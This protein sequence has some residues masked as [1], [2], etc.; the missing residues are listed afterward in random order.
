MADL[1]PVTL[2]DP[3]SSLRASYVPGAGMICT[4]LADNSIEYVGQRRGLQ[5]Y[6][7]DGK[8]MGI[9]ILYPWANRLSANEYRVAD[10]EV[11]V[12]PGTHGVRADAHGAPI[13]GVLAASPDWQVTE[14]T[15][16]ALVAQLDWDSDQARLATFPF[17][18]RLTVTVTLEDRALTVATAV[19]P[20]RDSSVPLCYGYHPYLTIP[21]VPRQDWQLHTPTMRHLPVDDRGLPTG[22]A[23]PWP[24][25]TMRLGSTELDDGFDDVSTGAVFTLSGGPH[26]IEVAFEQGYGAAQ[27]FAPAGDSVVGIEPMTA[28]TDAL[29]HGNYKMAAPGSPETATFSISV[30]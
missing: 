25:G 29:R 15:D 27:L 13:H 18:H 1:E 10:T 20:T 22:E 4:S 7:S 3:S 12:I 16:N 8:T 11:T 19:A 28:P 5:A 30:V 14:R 23:Q 6:V 9:P 26:R 21:G 17:P 24:G 2:Q